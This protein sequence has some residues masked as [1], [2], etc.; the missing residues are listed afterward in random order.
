MS[1]IFNSLFGKAVN[2]LE[3]SQALLPKDRLH[4]NAGHLLH[5]SVEKFFKSYLELCGITTY[6][7]NGKNGHELRLLLNML[8]KTDFPTSDYISLLRLQI[9]D[10]SGGYEFTLEEKQVNLKKYLPLVESL[11]KTVLKKYRS[12]GDT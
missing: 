8:E 7:K 3:S 2:D 4:D 10:S 11:K 12:L 9:Y 5:A 1:S 6:P